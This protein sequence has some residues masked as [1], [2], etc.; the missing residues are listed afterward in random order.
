M[1]PQTVVADETDI[2]DLYLPPTQMSASPVWRWRLR[3]GPVR[4]KRW[5]GE[6]RSGTREMSRG[7]KNGKN[8]IWVE[9]SRL[10]YFFDLYQ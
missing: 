5:M 10:L 6:F 1:V 2:K 8:C 4:V 7:A 3:L 9:E